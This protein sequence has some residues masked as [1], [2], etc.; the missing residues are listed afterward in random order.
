MCSSKQTK[1][2]QE[3]AENTRKKSSNGINNISSITAF[4]L[5]CFQLGFIAHYHLHWYRSSIV[6]SGSREQ[7]SRERWH[8][9][10][11]LVRNAAMLAGVCKSK[12]KYN[13]EQKRKQVSGEPTLRKI[14]ELMTNKRFLQALKNS[15]QPEDRMIDGNKPHRL[16]K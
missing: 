13:I 2:I 4:D 15:L 1:N 14:E 11:D 10:F 8:C 12:N 6:N 3:R 9:T 7:N 5:L 16:Q